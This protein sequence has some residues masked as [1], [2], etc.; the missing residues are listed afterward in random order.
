MKPVNPKKRLGQNFLNDKS[1]A[2]QIVSFL[3]VE[4]IQTIIEVGPGM[5]VLTKEILDL[6][7]IDKR[8]SVRQRVQQLT[9]KFPLPY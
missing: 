8:K 5:G 1:I 9:A 4:K 2:S 7:N 3:S 6:K